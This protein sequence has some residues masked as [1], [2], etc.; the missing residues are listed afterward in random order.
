MM[1]RNMLQ[2]RVERYLAD[3]NALS[4][5]LA[6]ASNSTLKNCLST[7]PNCTAVSAKGFAL[8]DA[9]NM[10]IAGAG[11]GSPVRYDING[12]SCTT[13]SS[14]CVFEV[15][16]TYTSTC[17]GTS[18][19]TNPSVTTQYTIQQA[20]GVSPI[21]G[22]PL[23]TISSPEVPLTASGAG[24]AP[25]PPTCTGE[26]SSL[27][28]TG[29]AWDCKAG[30]GINCVYTWSACTGGGTSPATQTTN[31][32]QPAANGGTPCPSSPKNC[33]YECYCAA[34]MNKTYFVT[35]KH[36]TQCQIIAGYPMYWTCSKVP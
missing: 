13:A 6:D 31:I 21:G 3:S 17:P 11:S 16:T 32:T 14:H 22:T 1:T 28:W 19:C 23:R 26:G 9:T 35:N 2:L 25:I 27:Q 7:T 33:G 29:S 15:F 30:A 10:K 8:F 12:A 20:V 34:I 36:A 5:T 4:K 18:P 24:A